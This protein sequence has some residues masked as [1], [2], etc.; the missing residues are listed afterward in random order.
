MRHH[1]FLVVKEALHNVVK[2]SG[3]TEVWLRIHVVDSTLEICV[4][5][6][7]KGLCQA[8]VHREGNG[9]LNMRQRME[10]MGGE[11][12]MTSEPGKGT[13]IRL[14]IEL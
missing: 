8:E 14:R 12:V 11:F 10:K 7:G 5:D 13:R 2:H 3:G 1:L 9:L 6:N 4:E